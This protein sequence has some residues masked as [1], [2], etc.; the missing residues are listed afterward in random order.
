[1]VEI[2]EICEDELG[3]FAAVRNAIWPH[4]PLTVEDLVDWRTQ[5]GGSRRSAAT[6]SWRST[7]SPRRLQRLIPPVGAYGPSHRHET[8]CID[9]KA[10]RV[11]TS[12]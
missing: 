1:M 12:P 8:C 9:Q 4:D 6:R 7:S 5:A 11:R 10:R 3:R 2:R